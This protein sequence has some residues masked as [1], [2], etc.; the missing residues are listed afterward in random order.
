MTIYPRL[1]FDW[2]FSYFIKMW[3]AAGREKAAVTNFGEVFGC[4][5]KNLTNSVGYEFL[6]KF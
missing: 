5:I 6:L 3:Y 1:T 4:V 2:A